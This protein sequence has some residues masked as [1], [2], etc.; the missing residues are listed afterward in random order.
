MVRSNFPS[1]YVFVFF[2]MFTASCCV[3]LYMLLSNG[4]IQF[5]RDIH[6][7]MYGF[8]NTRYDRLPLELFMIV[9]CNLTG[10]MGYVR[11]MQYFDNM[12]ISVA[13]LMEPGNLQSTCFVTYLPIDVLLT[14][15]CFELSCG[16]HLG[17]FHPCWITARCTWMVRKSVSCRWNY[18]CHSSRY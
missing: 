1:V 16:F 12:I 6:I 11:S 2:N 14:V 7:G 13:T 10:S 8:L 5:S 9:V 3:L 17:I 18:L 15:F 4:K